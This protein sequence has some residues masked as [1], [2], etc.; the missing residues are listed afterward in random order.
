MN[1]SWLCV[2]L[3]VLSSAAIAFAQ[4]FKCDGSL[5]TVLGGGSK[6]GKVCTM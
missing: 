6:F 3:V 1:I 5:Y 2:A 4:P